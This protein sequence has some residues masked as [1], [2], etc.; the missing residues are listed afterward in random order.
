MVV[1]NGRWVTDGC[2]C[3]IINVYAPNT[4]ALR[5]E[6]WDYIQTLVN[7]TMKTKDTGERVGRTSSWDIADISRFNNFI[8]GSDLTEIQLVGRSFTW[9]RP[10]GSK[11]P[12]VSLK[13]GRR[14]LSDHIPI[15]IEGAEKN[16]G[17]RPFKFF[18][19]WIHHQEYRPKI[20]EKKSVIERLDI[21]DD[22]LGLDSEKEE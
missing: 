4:P 20:E 8:R 17:P 5:W 9:Y 13:G 18:N 15:F 16:W 11:W 21:L 6:I 22:V 3:T 2:N 7:S 12:N 14:S 1:V 10:N 19:Q